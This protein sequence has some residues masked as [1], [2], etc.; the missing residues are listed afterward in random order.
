MTNEKKVYVCNG[1]KKPCVEMSETQKYGCAS[2]GNHQKA[3]WIE[4]YTPTKLVEA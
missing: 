4:A 1:C 2:Y 3:K